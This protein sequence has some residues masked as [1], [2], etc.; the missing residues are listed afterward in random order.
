MTAQ[1]STPMA[2]EPCLARA[3][4]VAFL[5]PRIGGLLDRPRGR[6]PG[7]LG[8]PDEELIET[9]AGDSADEARAFLQRFDP[10]RARRQ[11]VH[12]G[13]EVVCRH[14]PAFPSPL[15]DL[16]DPPAALFLV[17]AGERLAALARASPVTVVGTR[18]AS[19]YGLSMAQAIGSG[20]ARAGL[21]VVSGLALGIDA[22]AH[23]ACL[24]AG[25]LAV[26]VMAGGPDVAY[27]P[28]HRRL[29]RR[30]AQTGLVIS[31]FP[32]GHA[33]FRW[34][35][36]ARNRLM[37]ALGRMTVVVE[38][39]DPSGSL[40][41][42]DFAAHLGRAVGAVP[43]KV[44]TETARGTNGLLSD[45]ARV[46]TSVRDV[47]EEVLGPGADAPEPPRPEGTARAVLEAVEA[48]HGAA[49]I[50]R[51]TGLRAA[52]ARVA[53]TQLEADGW[54]TRVGLDRFEPAAR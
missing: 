53:L 43:G 4:L 41:T 15:L 12:R 2:C 1:R 49:G 3:Y 39:A 42:A 7:L 35:F 54:I 33:P 8:L 45:G 48:G 31:E 32:P 9:V 18:S 16:V 36:P 28:R 30:V 20:L 52:E 5:A 40:I 24:D 11:V 44:T 17:G 19:P 13:A 29:H 51:H 47:L 46:V 21:P 27:P 6:R 23:S 37:A 38:A 14:D 25:G 22:A 50:A 10:A 26:A 34:S